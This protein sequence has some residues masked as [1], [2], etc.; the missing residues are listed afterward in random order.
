MPAESDA[1]WVAVARR[2]RKHRVIGLLPASPAVAASEV[3]ARLGRAL[4]ALAG[5]PVLVVAGAPDPAAEP[6]DGAFTARTLDD[7][8]TLWSPRAGDPSARLPALAKLLSDGSGGFAHVVVDL[9]GLAARGEH[10]AAID[11]MDGVAVLARSGAT[12]EPELARVAGEVP[13]A[14]D[15]GVLLVERP[16]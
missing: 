1:D 15:L 13:A 16:R 4:G 11:L 3:A 9:G 10:L 7:A 12:S 2:V 5:G 14:R 8:V 6:G